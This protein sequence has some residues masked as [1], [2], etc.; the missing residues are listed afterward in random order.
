[1]YSVFNFFTRF[2][3]HLE[4]MKEYNLKLKHVGVTK[5]NVEFQYISLTFNL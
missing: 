3:L 2:D 4:T 5:N 1:M